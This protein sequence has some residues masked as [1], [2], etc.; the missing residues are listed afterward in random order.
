MDYKSRLISLN[1]FKVMIWKKWHL[2]QYKENEYDLFF[3]IFLL[4]VSKYS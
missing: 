1:K 4:V 2:Y 3:Y